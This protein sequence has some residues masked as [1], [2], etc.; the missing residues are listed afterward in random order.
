MR[1]S[2]GDL[3]DVRSTLADQASREGTLPDPDD[4]VAVGGT[5]GPGL[6]DSATGQDWT[7]DENR[8][9]V[10][11]Y[12]EMLLAEAQ[13]APYSKSAHRRELLRHLRSGRS[14][15]AIEFKHQNLSAAMVDLG[16]PYIKGYRP[17]GNYQRAL[18][19]EIQKQLLEWKGA[20][21]LLCAGRM[22]TPGAVAEFVAPPDVRPQ[23]PAIAAQ[24]L[25]T[26]D[27][28]ALQA[29]NTRLGGLG[30]SLVVELEKRRL[31]SAGRP[32]LAAMVIW[33]AS[34]EGNGAG[35]DVRS[36]QDSGSVLYIEVKTTALDAQTPFYMSSAE[37]SFARYHLDSYH[38]YRVY[39]VD[40][41]PKVFVIRDPLDSALDLTPVT[42]R[43]RLAAR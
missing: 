14:E 8:A 29:E 16:L 31:T 39:D 20:L 40:E 42:F 5:L 27:Y 22:A 11:E 2:R 25:R 15:A 1:P 21:E 36:C 3:I 10:A 33:V 19:D 24:R 7:A 4:K 9:T 18:A 34:D 32:D 28:M 30:E 13:G 26:V 12:F 41:Q 37:L 35:Y 38:L 43:A 6:P 17:R 23:R